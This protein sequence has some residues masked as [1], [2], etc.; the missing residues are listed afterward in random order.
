[1]SLLLDPR[2]QV[3]TI[4]GATVICGPGEYPLPTFE[5]T[6]GAG[7]PAV[8]SAGG[9]GAPAKSKSQLKK[10]LKGP[11]KP[12]GE[13][14]FLVAAAAAD[15]EKEK[16]KKEKEEK[17]KKPV[18][19]VA[20]ENTTPAG[21]KKDVTAPMLKA[22]H[23]QAVEAAWNDW[24]TAQ[25]FFSADPVAAAKAAPENKFIMVIPPPNVTGSLHLGHALTSAVE[26]ALTR[27]HRMT[28]KHVLWLPGTDH[29]G[30]ATQ[31][32]VERRLK[33]D[34]DITRHDL[35]REAF[36]AEVWK[37][38]EQYGTKITSQLRHLGVSV[39]WS[40]ERFTM[41]SMLSEGVKEA[42]VRFYESGL[43]TRGTRLV[44]WCCR[45]ATAIA[46][47]EVDYLELDG[48]TNIRV[49][50]HDQD[51]TYEF[52]VITS[53]AYKVVG[54]DEEI[55]VATTRPETMLG[56]SAVA[57]HPDDPRYTALHGKFLQHPFHE[58]TIPIILD[59]ILVDMAF[60]TGAVKVTPAHDPN[61]FLTGRRHGL[62]EITVFS[63]DG[64]VNENGGKFAGLMRFDAREAVIAELQALGLYRG[65]APNPMRL[66]VCSRSGDVIEPLLK[67]QWWVDCKGMAKR[68]ADAVRDGSL[69][70]VPSFHEDTWYRWLDN[71]Q[72]WCVSRQLW[73]GH[74]IP[75]WKVT[76]ASGG[77]PAGGEMWIVA[78]S[79]EAALAQAVE[80]TKLPAEALVLKQDPDVLDTWFSS[81]LFPFSTF[82]WPNTDHP[83]F[84]AFYPNS[85]LETGHDILFF[86][87]AR[88]VM[89]GLQLTDKLPFH[90]VYLHA[91]VRDKYGRKMSKSLGNVI[92]P[93]EVINGIDLESLHQKIREGNLP[94]K[95]VVKAIEGQKLDYP[96][97]IPECGADALRFGLLKYTIQGRDI[98]LDIGQIVGHRQFCNKLWQATQFVLL[99]LQSYTHTGTMT[100][101]IASLA[102]AT[103]KDKWILSRL[104]ATIIAVTEAMKDYQFSAACQATYDLWQKDFCDNY[105]EMSKPALRGEDAA[106]KLTTQKSLLLVVELGLR[107]LHP[108]MPFVTEE[109]WQ[110]LPNRGAPWSATIPDPPSIV[111]AQWPHPLEAFADAGIDADVAFVQAIVKKGRSLK[112]AGNVTKSAPILVVS[113]DTTVIETFKLEIAT[114]IGAAP[115][116]ISTSAPADPSN[117][118]SM[119]V[120]D[121]TFVYMQISDGTVDISAQLAK[122]NKEVEKF[123]Y[124]VAGLRAE[125]TGPGFTKVPEKVQK[126]KTEK[127]AAYE[128]ELEAQIAARDQV[129]LL[130]KK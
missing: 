120:D 49:P 72:D 6:G 79:E 84:K 71:I 75:A 34:R 93:M 32:V 98:N 108:F 118:T 121:S 38:K 110:H 36:V 106:S 67:P 62:P 126:L 56:D 63:E 20:F 10:E 113:A 117:Y 65:K 8:P 112:E 21:E 73:W 1:M 119:A 31:S 3:R 102:G 109:L 11:K 53:F 129:L 22:Y 50:G 60:G 128:K 64:K 27:W 40:R 86:W 55:V 59:P 77:D 26:D 12:K 68:A 14:P 37:W 45:L 41:D 43:M 104:N 58:R 7:G 18:E 122:M 15:P 52:G 16:K 4:G 48:P 28:G 97:G 99:N 33:K 92:D 114:L 42:F 91:M 74:R 130:A 13:K 88:M 24:W 17:K 111:V 51:K 100:D 66:G 90:T 101:L 61:D 116:S 103:G 94:E 96:E 9:D 25:G 29:A 46:D 124:L 47:I 30:I 70:L 89:M 105:I 19:A 5:V 107:L 83:D 69:K 23:P 2:F 76:L 78:R 85:I 44:N 125:V 82:G 81:G 54:S 39:D 115:F 87:V 35:G 57:V 95:E 80:K 123:T 127:L